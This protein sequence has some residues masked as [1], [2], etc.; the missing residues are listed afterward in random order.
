MLVQ[1]KNLQLGWTWEHGLAKHSWKGCIKECVSYDFK[2]I[3]LHFYMAKHG[4]VGV[5]AQICCFK[6]VINQVIIS[7]QLV[8][9]SKCLFWEI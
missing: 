6:V 7:H 5:S 2:S 4:L 9:I 8:N 3:S 1:R